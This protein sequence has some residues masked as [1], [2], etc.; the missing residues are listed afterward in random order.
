[1]GIQ[2]IPQ[3]V[4]LTGS[5]DDKSL[6]VAELLFKNGFREAYAIQGGVKGKNGWLSIQE[7]LLPPSVHIFPKKKKKKLQQ[8]EIYGGIN[9]QS[10]SADQSSVSSRTQ[11]SN[12][13]VSKSVE[14]TAETKNSARSLSPYPKYPDL[15]P[16]SSPTPSKPKS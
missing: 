2:Q 7:T 11:T 14:P 4:F 15:K 10:D 12:G 16:P 3:S 13:Y 5:F 1:M 6:K 8:P 9:Q